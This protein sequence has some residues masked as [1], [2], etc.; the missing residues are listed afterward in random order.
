VA[1]ALVKVSGDF[2]MLHRSAWFAGVGAKGVQYLPAK[3]F[4]VK[5]LLRA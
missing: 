3:N 5:R 1:L 4:V 2:V